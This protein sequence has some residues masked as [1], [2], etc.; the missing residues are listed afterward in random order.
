MKSLLARLLLVV[1]VAMVPALGFQAYTEIGAR[2][3]RQQF[4]DGEALRLMHVISSEQA[5]IAEGAE[6][7]LNVLS[8]APAV[9]DGLADLCQRVLANLL[10]QSPRYVFAAV[11]GLNGHAICA[12]YP[13][14]PGFDA[15][16]RAYFRLALQTGGFA[17]GEYAISKFSPA[18][19]HSYGQAVHGQGRGSRRGGHVGPESGLARPST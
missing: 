2:H 10:K 18:G 4:E 7:V 12:P 1:S 14:S 9:Q 5:R 11:I 15:R 3:A 13:V 17:I 19:D 6:Q 16:G 8:G